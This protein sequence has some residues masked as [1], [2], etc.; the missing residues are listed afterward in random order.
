VK[1]NVVTVGVTNVESSVAK[2]LVAKYGN[3][4]SVFKDDPLELRT[5]AV[6][7]G[8]NQARRQNFHPAPRRGG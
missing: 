4:V 6:A 3:I 2:G 7:P 8:R 5:D 1:Q